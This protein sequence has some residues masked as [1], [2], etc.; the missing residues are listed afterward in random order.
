MANL[1]HLYSNPIHPEI[2]NGTVKWVAS[3]NIRPIKKLPLIFWSSGDQWDEV[4]LWA[5]ERA[6]NRDVK[7]KTV[8]TQMEHLHKYANWLEE[9]QIDWRHFPQKK[10]ERVLVLWRGFLVNLRDQGYLGASTTTARMNAVI[11]FYRYADAHNFICHGERM[12]KDKSVVI[13][14]YDTVGFKR[15]LQRITTDLSIASAYG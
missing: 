5:L 8:I 2:Q 14:Y 15:S 12:W 6:R 11:Q 1:E 9:T 13:N 4:N 7:L 3:K 10:A